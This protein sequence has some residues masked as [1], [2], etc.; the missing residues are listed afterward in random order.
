[1]LTEPPAPEVVADSPT[2]GTVVASGGPPMPSPKLHPCRI[3][4]VEDE[5]LVAQVLADLFAID[6]HE[7]D[8]DRDGGIAL[9]RLAAG[10]YDMIVSD[11]RMPG[12]DGPGLYR[13]VERRWP[14]RCGRFVFLTGDTVTPEAARALEASGAI[15]L[16]KPVALAEV[17]EVVQRVLQGRVPG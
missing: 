4:L 10:S 6:G 5:T 11:V 14:E 2:S 1:M 8:I 17:R 9:D 15:T 16:A 13:E 3:L 12:L 7:V